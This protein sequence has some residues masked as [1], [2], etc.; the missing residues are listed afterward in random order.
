VFSIVVSATVSR[1]INS[2]IH[3]VKLNKYGNGIDFRSVRELAKVFKETNVKKEEDRSYKGRKILNF[4]TKSTYG[5]GNGDKKMSSHTNVNIIPFSLKTKNYK[6]EVIDKWD[7]KRKPYQNVNII[8]Y[9]PSKYPLKRKTLNDKLS[10]EN[11]ILRPELNF[12]SNARPAMLK[13][14]EMEIE[15]TPILKAQKAHKYKAY[16][17]KQRKKYSSQVPIHLGYSRQFVDPSE[18]SQSKAMRGRLSTLPGSSMTWLP[19]ARWNGQPSSILTFKYPLRSRQ[20]YN[21][22]DEFDNY[23]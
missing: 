23:L 21:N 14:R 19:S 22:V 7:K 4:A 13:W 20:L 17:A 15:E 11:D 1:M 6:R 9:S 10:S 18:Y 5:V 16:K 2:P 3:F 8:P 12:V